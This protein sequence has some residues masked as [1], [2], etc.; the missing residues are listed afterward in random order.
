MSF[1]EVR[2]L[3][4][5]SCWILH[6]M[7]PIER[8]RGYPLVVVRTMQ[9]RHI[10]YFQLSHIF[11]MDFAIIFEL[12]A[13]LVLIFGKS[14]RTGALSSSSL[15]LLQCHLLLPNLHVCLQS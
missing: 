3:R 6:Q 15:A 7:V 10:S 9:P 1:C 11:N 8:V 12:L 2:S 13:P 5:H 14:T 4:Y